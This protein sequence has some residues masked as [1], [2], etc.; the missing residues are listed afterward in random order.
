[1]GKKILIFGILALFVIAGCSSQQTI[2]KHCNIE[3]QTFG[4]KVCDLSRREYGYLKQDICINGQIKTADVKACD[5]GK[6]CENAGFC[7]DISVDQFTNGQDCGSYQDPFNRVFAS[8]SPCKGDSSLT[9][10]VM[11]YKGYRLLCVRDVAYPKLKIEEG[12]KC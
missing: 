9:C 1:M 3:G 12:G 7:K 4:E 8:Q 11:C 2:Q 10:G 6:T 5:I